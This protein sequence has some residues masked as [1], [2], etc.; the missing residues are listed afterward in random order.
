V[1]K[2]TRGCGAIATVFK[3]RATMTQHRTGPGMVFSPLD[4]INQVLASHGW[5]INTAFIELMNLSVAGM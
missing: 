4:V 3:K 5:Q 2:L 1:F